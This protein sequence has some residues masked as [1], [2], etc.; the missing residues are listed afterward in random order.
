MAT[1]TLTRLWINLL[2]DGSAISAYSSDRSRSYTVPTDV[3]TY[4]G[5]RQRAV[6]AEGAKRQFEFTLTPVIAAT[7]TQLEAWAGQTVQVR[8]HR[9]QRFYGVY[10]TVGV[11][12]LRDGTYTASISLQGVTVEQE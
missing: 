2:A 4:A 5:G 11:G 3:R 12:E 10:A 9:G 7:V 8:D 1:L 6:T